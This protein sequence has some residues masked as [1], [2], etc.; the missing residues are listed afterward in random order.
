MYPPPGPIA[1]LMWAV[2][3]TFRSPVVVEGHAH[4]CTSGH[5]P[6]VGWINTMTGESHFPESNGSRHV[7]VEVKFFN[8][9]HQLATLIGV[10]RAHVGSKG[11]IDGG[12][13]EFEDVT[14]EPGGARAERSFTLCP[15]NDSGLK[16]TGGE[17][18]DIAFRLTRGGS[19]FG[20]PSVG[21]VL[22][23]D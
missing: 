9:S 4:V 20:T 2:V 12:F 22:S 5:G 23:G 11:L 19:R 21:L 13:E 14:L 1:R 6:L 3:D 10:K 16:L 15:P 7:D 18:V 17:T 8:R